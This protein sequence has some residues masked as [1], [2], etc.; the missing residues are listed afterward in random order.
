MEAARSRSKAKGPGELHRG[1]RA[2]PVPWTKPRAGASR[3]SRPATRELG[4]KLG[5]TPRYARGT[6][7]QTAPKPCLPRASPAARRGTAGSKAATPSPRRR[8]PGDRQPWPRGCGEVGKRRA[9][10]SR[11][12]VRLS[13]LRLGFYWACHGPAARRAPHVRAMAYV[14]HARPDCPRPPGAHACR[15]D[16]FATGAA[17]ASLRC[18][19]RRLGPKRDA[20]RSAV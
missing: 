6:V 9:P 15:P 12:R 2:G 19:P 13:S 8:R 11:A 18:L 3:S 20:R 1:P 5:L 17:F 14:L 16:L 10:M 4:D 7:S